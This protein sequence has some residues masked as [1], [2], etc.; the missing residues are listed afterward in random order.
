M[1][2]NKNNEE[3]NKR[4]YVAMTVYKIIIYMLKRCSVVQRH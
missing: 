2:K 3:L 4:L 1:A